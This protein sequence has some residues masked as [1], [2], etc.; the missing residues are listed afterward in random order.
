MSQQIISNGEGGLSVLNAINGN[1]TEL[2]GALVF[3]IKLGALSANAEQQILANTFVQLI[4]IGYNAGAPTIRIGTTGG[5]N[6]ILPDTVISQFTPLSLMQGFTT[7][8]ILYFTISGGSI[9]ITL[10]VNPNIL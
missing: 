8:Q 7:T 9:S 3:P 10:L 6:Q 1:F 5:G 4:L 2:Y